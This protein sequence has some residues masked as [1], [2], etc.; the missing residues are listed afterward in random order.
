MYDA[1]ESCRLW[2]DVDEAGESLVVP[3]GETL[4]DADC[5]VSATRVSTRRVLT[6]LSRRTSCAG[7]L[8]MFASIQDL[9]GVL[10]SASLDVYSDIVTE[11]VGSSMTV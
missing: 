11:D 8:L 10:G 6:R 1:V 5:R 2:F 3:D 4:L 9:E 7:W